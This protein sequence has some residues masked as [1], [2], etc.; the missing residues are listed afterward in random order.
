MSA[1]T[2]P[3]SSVW[4]QVRSYSPP[5]R[6][7]PVIVTFALFLGM[8][9]A[10]G[11]R[12]DGFTDPQ[13]FLSLLLDN[14]FLIVLAVGMTFVI[15]AGGID[16]SVGSVVALSTMIAAKTLALGWSPY[17][18]IVTVLV[19]ATLLG[20]LMGLLIHYFEIQP[21]IATLA[22][23]FLARGLTYL[24]SVESI[25]ITDQTFSELAFRTIT[26]PGG[27]YTTWTVVI[28]VATVA[29]AAYVLARTRFGRTVYAVGGNEASALL[30][31]L[32]VAVVKVGVYAISGFCAGLGGLLF[33]LYTLSGYSLHAVGMEL[34][35]IAA[36]V[37]GGTL[38]TGG[39]GYVLGSL[40]GVLVL[41]TIQTFISFDGGL[42]SWWTRI[43]IG[44]LLL[45]FVVVQRVMTRRQ[46]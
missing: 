13:V 21:F 11:L 42:S 15:L 45:V 34:D 16:L 18:S 44:V 17:L 28:A 30:M 20:T 39:R 38:L 40:V 19:V 24:I 22:G 29:V 31:G 8:F 46:P 26:L 4:D 12:Y 1:V 2:A 27:Y 25:P 37:I 41:G 36:V 10:G 35:A 14:S 9:G 32:R 6:F 7:L 3:S 5:A 23:L 33:A 43:A